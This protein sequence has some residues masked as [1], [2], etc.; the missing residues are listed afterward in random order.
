[1]PLLE[2][3]CGEGRESINGPITLYYTN[4]MFRSWRGFNGLVQ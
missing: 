3:L 4:G 2:M 1:M